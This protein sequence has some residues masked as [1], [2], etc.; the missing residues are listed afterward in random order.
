MITIKNN[1]YLNFILKLYILN[2]SLI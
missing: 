2:Y 1:L